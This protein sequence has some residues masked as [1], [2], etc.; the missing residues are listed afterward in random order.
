MF[1]IGTTIAGEFTLRDPFTGESANADS[2][3]T[4]VLVRNGTA[5]AVVVTITNSA[6]GVYKWSADLPADYA[7]GD[8]I[9]IRVSAEVGGVADSVDV[10]DDSAELLPY[11]VRGALSLKTTSGDDVQFLV[12]LELDG[13][14]VD[15]SA[16]SPD[17][18]CEASVYVQETDLPLFTVDSE[19]A[20]NGRGM[21]EAEYADPNFANDRMHSAKFTLTYNDQSYF[22]TVSF[23][24]VS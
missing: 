22:G 23:A 18:T 16:S 14:V 6:T 2:L 19:F 24:P 20:L 5:T 17:A 9:Q 21:F 11:R 1:L 13:A 7:R 8:R 15:L 12:W 3:P 10:A 4:A